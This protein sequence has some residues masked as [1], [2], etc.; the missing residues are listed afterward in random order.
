MRKLGRTASDSLDLLLDTMCSIFGG[1]ILIAIFIVLVTQ[2]RT[3]NTP[4]TPSAADEM[5]QRKISVATQDLAEARKLKEALES[6]APGVPQAVVSELEELQKAVV[7]AREEKAQLE[8]KVGNQVALATEDFTAISKDLSKQ[9]AEANRKGRELGNEI[10]AHNVELERQRERLSSLAEQIQKLRSE[11]TTKLRFPVERT[12]SKGVFP[13]IF[14][15]NCIYPLHDYRLEQNTAMIR[16]TPNGR[17][18]NASPIDGKGWDPQR[19]HSEI[20]RLFRSLS[21]DKFY[22]ALYVYSDSFDCF[23]RFKEM[24][25]ESGFDFGWEP[26]QS[27]ELLRFGSDGHSPPPL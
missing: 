13:I 4:E 14:Q 11:R 8:G 16:W 24:A 3:D 7:A 19:H 18:Q 9:T 10:K 26:V 20:H 21:K 25:T 6:A 1:I 22:F 5:L 23:N 27:G 17:A 12:T 2:D 15:Y